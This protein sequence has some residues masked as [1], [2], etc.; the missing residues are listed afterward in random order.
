MMTTIT[1]T[2][3]KIW[4]GMAGGESFSQTATSD[5]Q[6]WADEYPYFAP[7][8]YFLAARLKNNNSPLAATQLVKTN[9]YF[10]NPLWLQ[11][12]LQEIFTKVE[13]LQVSPDQIQEEIKKDGDTGSETRETVESG[14]KIS[15]I[16]SDQ[17]ADFKKPVEPGAR[18]EIDA[19]QGKLHTIDYFASL[20]IKVDLANMPK[21][22]LT[23]NLLKFTDWLK[24]MKQLDSGNPPQIS[25][26][27]EGE[28]AV[29]ETAKNSNQPREILTEA[30][31]E[32][33]E[34]QGQL[35][36]AI[37]LYIKLSFLIPEKSSY[38]A[39]KIEQLKGI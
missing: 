20:G 15:G 8:Q 25:S 7:V 1:G 17:L 11:L 28:N 29:A 37:Q 30:M 22:K 14:S 31:A 38:F 39:A 32:V 3:E 16:L 6:R 4:T 10:T 35:E 2:Q 9:Y 24:Q 27:P 34:K 26:N 21:D 36:K 23:T 33:L 12:H 13:S 5:L 18:L 19:L